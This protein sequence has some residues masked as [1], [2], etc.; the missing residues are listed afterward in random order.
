MLNENLNI[1][2]NLNEKFKKELFEL[3]KSLLIAI[4]AA[5]IIITFIFQTVSVDGSSMY[6][7]LRN[8]DRLI[9]EKVTYYFRK[10]QPADIIVM[11]NPQ[12]TNERYIKRV[13]AVEGDKVAIYNNKVYINGNSKDEP[14]IFENSINDFNEITVPKNTVFVLGDNRN[15]STDSRI[16]GP[17][18]LKLISGKAFIRLLPF[19]KSGRIR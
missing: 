16:L 19:N 11:K 14:Y 18:D 15:N 8:N 10:P 17:I 13:I 3:C 6:P 5:T 4:I 7:T 1:K 12:N 9:I 2:N